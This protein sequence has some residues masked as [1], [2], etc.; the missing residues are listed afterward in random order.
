MTDRVNDERKGFF[1]NRL[2]LS[3][4]ILIGLVAG[5]A[6]GVI[7]GEYCAW[8]SVIGEAFIDL[9]Q[10]TILPYITAALILNI[11]R[12]S[13]G[14]ARRLAGH[15][16]IVLLVLWAVAGVA[17]VTAPLAF[18]AVDRGSFFSS[19]MVQTPDEF[20][21]L[22]LY[23]PENPFHSLANNVVPAV[24]L[25]SICLGVA[26]I[27]VERKEGFLDVLDVVCQ[28][29]TRVS[30]FVVKLTPYGIFAISAAAAGTMTLEELS[31]IHAYLI[32]YTAVGLV[33]ALWVLPLLVA[34]V[35]PFSYRQV[36]T[37]SR[38]AMVTAFATGKLFVVLPL[39]IEASRRLFEQLE[40]DGREGEDSASVLVP[41]AYP[42]PSVGKL[43]A[44]LFIPFG[45]WFVGSPLSFLQYPL[46]FGTGLLSLFGSPL[47]AIPFL[48]DL[49][50]LPADLFN[51]FVMSGVW[52]TRISDAVG[53]MHLF[54]FSVLAACAMAGM[55]QIRWRRLAGVVLSGGA[56]TVIV[57][58]GVRFHLE[59]VKLGAA[60]GV[61]AIDAMT[62]RRELAPHTVLEHASP[63]PVPLEEGQSR[64]ARI[65]ETGV[66][67][68]G[69]DPEALPFAYFNV[70]GDLVGFDVEMAHRL[71]L[72]LG[73]AIEF[74]PFHLE[75]LADQLAEDHFDVAMAG[76]AATFELL[77]MAVIA[78][79]GIEV[80]GALVIADHLRDEVASIDAIRALDHA[81]FGVVGY[82][83]ISSRFHERLPNVEVVEIA[84]NHEFFE[85]ATSDVMA[86]LTIA[87]IGA[88]WT[89]RYPGFHVVVP[90]G[91]DVKGQLAYPIGGG[92]LV[93]RSYVERWATLVREDGTVDE[94]YAHW[95]LG[96]GAKTRGPRWSVIRNVLH[97]VE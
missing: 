44:L 15:A 82:P 24:V 87:E 40:H 12:L 70:E 4:R 90:D 78:F 80:T 76:V 31:R 68:V 7:F 47:A 75:T 66:I 95:V 72:E 48:L 3:S 65:R 41:L 69:F 45:A 61:A 88:A 59:A 50:R 14:Q 57:L 25:F 64:L 97:W 89:V 52:A 73:V 58:G 35:T 11:G 28:A 96:G 54:A 38:D 60:D 77:E 34:S 46:L 36:V 5:V 1:L 91:V 71:A 26:L 53:A 8:L 62:Y 33:L 16:G 10:M 92:D 81:R 18:P 83:W 2:S 56:V 13:A 19:S 37:A 23:I 20:D 51:L 39:L 94:L 86:L 49:F 85:G 63:N 84:E 30:T 67:R 93:F 42:F 43:L 29:L 27:G 21:P 17:L 6:C 74:V 9:L 32:V 55:V 79:S 22:A